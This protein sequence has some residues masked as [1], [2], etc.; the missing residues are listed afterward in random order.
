MW[1][2]AALMERSDIGT[3]YEEAH[4]GK[5]DPHNAWLW[6]PEGVNIV[7][8]KSVYLGAWSFK[9]QLTSTAQAGNDK[10]LLDHHP[11]GYRR[12]CGEGNI[13]TAAYTMQGTNRRMFFSHY[14]WSLLGTFSKTKEV[15]GTIFL[16]C[17][18]AKAKSS[19]G[20]AGMYKHLLNNLVTVCHDYDFT[21]G[22]SHSK[23]DRPRHSSRKI[24]LKPGMCAAQLPGTWLPLCS[25]SRFHK[26]PSHLWVPCPA[27]KCTVSAMKHPHILPSQ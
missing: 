27:M 18:P 2:E 23:P 12:L 6:K 25:A 7:T 19:L 14:F 1:K 5:T 3:S 9:R 8:V 21:W 17:S 26:E 15:A 16:H 13:Q 10:W 20:E 22:L 11:L 4:M 24:L